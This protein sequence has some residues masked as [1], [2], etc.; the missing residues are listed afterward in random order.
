MKS[1]LFIIL[2]FIINA[3]FVFADVYKWVDENGVTHYSDAPHNVDTK[4]E[5]I[6]VIIEYDEAKKELQTLQNKLKAS[7][8]KELQIQNEIRRIDNDV[9]E[10]R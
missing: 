4:T 3:S 2:I 7:K 9:K 8:E 6:Q 5:N 1:F 10:S